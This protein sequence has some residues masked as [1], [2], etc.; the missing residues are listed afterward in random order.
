MP[1][2]VVFEKASVWCYRIYD[3]A[4]A[5]RL[6]R[7]QTLLAADVRRLKLAREGS[8]YL[9]LPNPPLTVQMGQRSLRL[10]HG[11]VLVDAVA[12]IFDHGAMSI[13]LKVPVEEGTT[14]DALTP[15]ADELYDAQAVDALSHELVEGLRKALE[16]AVEG[17]HL[18]DQSE[19]YTVI[20][21]EALE[22]RPSGADVLARGDVTRLLLGEVG[23]RPL[24]AGERTEVTR[25]S[26]SYTVDDLAVV[27]WNSAFV[28]EPSGSTDILD[29][30]EICNAQLLELRYYDDLLDT[31][32]TRIYDQMERPKRRPGNL[33][34][35]PYRV[36]ARRV[37]VTWM[38]FSEFVERVENSL[39][40][41]GDTY[42]ARVYEAA[43][44]SVRIPVWQA[45]VQRKQ[46]MLG[47]IYQLLKGEVDTARSLTLE[48][49]IVVLIVGELL[50]A[51]GPWFHR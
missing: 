38:E 19:S 11:A 10:R 9:E 41:V 13:I 24:S 18:W 43:V 26:F 50:L 12:R 14:L 27:D 42:L 5:I 49:I 16:P 51:L 6:E 35:S 48:V 45:S 46:Q 25:H 39:K 2:Q 1:E 34:R 28:Y 37:L 15:L 20:F 4:Q 47:N 44:Q 32:L 31:Q 8:E 21:A 33:F 30:L 29:L 40:I 17:P 36:L 23:N 22:G 7:A 3:I